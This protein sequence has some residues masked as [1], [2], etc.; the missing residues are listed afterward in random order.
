MFKKDTIRRTID[1]YRAV[2]A[3]EV[4]AA[5]ALVSPIFIHFELPAVRPTMIARPTSLETGSA[6]SLEERRR[7]VA[8]VIKG[9]TKADLHYC[10]TV[11]V[12]ASSSHHN[13]LSAFIGT[14]VNRSSSLYL[15]TA[16]SHYARALPFLYRDEPSM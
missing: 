8:R 14:A 10:V 16:M 9:K 5:Y 15:E 12:S 13:I 6:R 4:S 3:A 1:A 2:T 7:T 11:P